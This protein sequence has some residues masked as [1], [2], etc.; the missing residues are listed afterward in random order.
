M[1]GMYYT[2]RDILEP[3]TE[4]GDF[5]KRAYDIVSNPP[6]S[7]HLCEIGWDLYDRRQWRALDE[8]KRT[9]NDCWSKVI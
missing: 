7:I 5:L 2:P 3:R 4:S 6:Y 1:A 9:C 8:H